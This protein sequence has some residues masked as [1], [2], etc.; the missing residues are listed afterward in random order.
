MSLSAVL[1]IVNNLF[2]MLG[3]VAVF[4]IGMDMMGNNLEKAAGKGIRSLMNKAAKNRITGIA[5][6]TAVTAIVNSSSAT[7][8]MIV[9]FVNV[10]L[11]TL[12]QSVPIIMGANIGTTISAFIM[13]L[14][15]SGAELEVS[16]I[17]ALVAFIGFLLTMV[18]KS[19]KVKR[20]GFILAGVGLIFVGLHVMSDAVGELTED[21]S[22]VRGVIESLFQSLGNGK[23]TLTWEMPVLF[24]IGMALTALVQASSAVTAIAISL[25]ANNLISLQMAMFIVMGT[26]V[27]TC[28]TAI[29]SSVGTNTNAKRTAVVH[30]LFNIFGSVLFFVPI[31]IWGNDLAVFLSKFIP[32]TQWQIAIFHMCFNLVTTFVLM[33]FDKYLVKLACILVPEKEQED[34]PV[35]KV[36]IL[37]E[38]LLKSPAVA[39]GEVRKEIVKMSR[40]AFGNYKLSLNM[41]LS[42]DT[43][44]QEQFNETEKQ[45]NSLNRYITSFLVKLASQEIA[46]NDEKKVGSFYHVVSDLERIG[47]YAQNITEYAQIM[48]DKGHTFSEHAADEI[49]KMDTHLTNLYNFVEKAFAE[50]DRKLFEKI[51]VEEQETDK[52]KAIMQASHVRRMDKGT[53]TAEV[54]AVFLQLAA[55]MERIGDHMHN[56]SNSIK[57]YN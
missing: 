45:I 5:T 15:S 10:G 48:V 34:Q 56:V 38:R 12:S 52:M 13:A 28:V 39:V 31:A 20:V 3:G 7:T 32:N 50:K 35:A 37:D 36:E 24:L 42:Y 51:E 43:S 46:E 8:V 53:C 21:G 6:G 26:N 55:D 40:L 18:G 19:D 29:L 23:D 44:A 41:L 17:F 14:S 4:M 11:M 47:D 30:L 54:G 1:Q 22:E 33:W 16:A 27:G 9:G 57:D 25:A 2:F 49:T